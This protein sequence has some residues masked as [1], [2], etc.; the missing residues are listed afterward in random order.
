MLTALLTAALLSGDP[1]GTSAMT[2]TLL[3]NA[4]RVVVQEI[5]YSPVVAV[6]IAYGVGSLDERDGARGMSHFC[7]HMMFRGTE[8]MPGSRLWQM[9]QRD[10]GWANAFTSNDV[11]VYFEVLPS[12]RLVDALAIESDR[13]QGALF[14]SSDAVAERNVIL[15]ELRMSSMDD[16]DGVLL[17]ALNQAA[18]TAHPYRHPV[19]GYEGDVSGFDSE[20]ARDYYRSFYT[21]DNAVLVLVGDIDTGRALEMVDSLF[22]GASPGDMHAADI[23]V[24]PVQTGPR[25]VDI[26]HPSTMTRL[27]IGFHVPSATSGDAAELDLISTLLSGGR[28][29]WLETALVQEGIASEAWAMN[30][31]GIDPGLFYIGAT[32]MPGVGFEEAESV[33]WSLLDSLSTVP[34]PDVELQSLANRARAGAVMEESSPVGRVISLAY[35][36]AAYGDPAFGDRRLEETMA[37]TASDITE[38]AA[39]YF[40]RDNS[41]TA[42]LE[43]TGSG[44]GMERERAAL[45]VDIEAPSEISYEGLSIPASMLVSTGRSVSDG[46]EISELPNGLVLMTSEDHT[47][48]LVSL[49]FSIPMGSRMSPVEKAG[50]AEMTAAAM[51][52][53]TDELDYASFHGRLEDEGTSLGLRA[54]GEY[55]SGGSTMLSEDLPL[56]VESAAGILIRPALRDEDIDQ[57]RDEQLA[58]VRQRSESVFSVAREQLSRMLLEDPAEA[59]I[60]TEQTT[61]AV[62]NDDVRNFWRICSRPSGAVIA[63][64]GDVT[65]EEALELVETWFGG[66]TSPEEDLPSIETPTLSQAPGDTAVTSVPGRVQAAVFTGVPGPSLESPMYHAFSTVSSILG[67]GIGSRLGH[68]VRDEQGLAYSVGSWN[69]ASRDIGYF[70][71]FLSTRADYAPQALSSVIFECG[72][73]AVEEVAPIELQLQQ[74]MTVGENALS[75]MTYDGRVSIL[76][77]NAARGLPADQDRISEEL[78]LGLSVEDIREAAAFYFGSGRW[79]VSVAGGLDE[80]M[81]PLAN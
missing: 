78:V 66:W 58:Y 27:A 28:S 60:V 33:I 48:P 69:P 59:R 47:F 77:A 16:P 40:R 6:A 67:S 3:P 10:G 34:L 35:S 8:T 11:T 4:L 26:T 65:H 45:P 63:I 15:D 57:C 49:G 79:F 9:I 29:S 46:V 30:G 71:A 23:P 64:A 31:G 51:L 55:T 75:G 61:L 32:L 25:C 41:T 24:E 68:S 50:I 37:T 42:R 80:D 52:Y 13:M 72:R 56:V 7:E 36:A 81:E 22:G 2:D 38:V 70:T 5:H 54:M 12:S 73:M 1:S 62:S 17:D 53:G 74:A 20:S 14:D 39:R 21:P 19:I 44:P 18:F 76:V 43:P